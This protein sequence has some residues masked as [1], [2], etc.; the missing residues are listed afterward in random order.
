MIASNTNIADWCP[1]VLLVPIACDCY[2]CDLFLV[3]RISLVADLVTVNMNSLFSQLV[4][5]IIHF[6]ELMLHMNPVKLDQPIIQG[7][8]LIKV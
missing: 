6:I 4:R 2:L 1:C 7:S 8:M 3:A 5:R